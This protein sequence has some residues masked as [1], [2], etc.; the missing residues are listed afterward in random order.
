M[1]EAKTYFKA[2]KVNVCELTLRLPRMCVEINL[3][4]YNGVKAVKTAYVK[5]MWRC[6]RCEITTTM[7][8]CIVGLLPWCQYEKFPDPEMHDVHIRFFRPARIIWT[9]TPIPATDPYEWHNV[10][11][12]H[13]GHVARMMR[14][15][16]M[17]PVD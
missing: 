2:H 9:P 5:H 16:S 12:V 10:I 4:Q 14:A 7:F 15:P 17:D 6:S 1:W 13:T 8:K 11:D 3:K